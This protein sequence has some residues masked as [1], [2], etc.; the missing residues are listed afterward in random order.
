MFKDGVT[1]SW[2]F[3]EPGG[4]MTG[5]FTWVVVGEVLMVGV[6]DFVCEERESDVVILPGG[7]DPGT[8]RGLVTVEGAPPW[9]T[10]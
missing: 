9:V 5:G 6:S 3:D 8:L 2:E 4:T 10:L 7:W 1:R